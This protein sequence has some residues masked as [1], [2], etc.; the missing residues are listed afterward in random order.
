LAGL[1]CHDREEERVSLRVARY[2]EDILID[3]CDRTWRVVL[4]TPAGWQI[5]NE[6]PLAFTRSGSMQPLPYPVS[7]K[8]SLAPLWELLNVTETQRSLVAGVLLNGYHPEGPYFVTNYVGEHGSAKTS[9]ARSHRQLIDPSQNPLRSPPKEENDPFAQAINNRCVA[10]DNLSYLPLWLSDALC[11]IATG[12]GLSKRKLYT[13]ADEM[14]QELKRPVIINGIED[15]ATRP[16][17]ADRVVQIELETIPDEARITEKVLWHKFEKVRAT[18]FAAILDALVLVLRTQP[19]LKMPPMPRMA[20]AVEWATA[21]ETAFGF[22]RWTFMRP[23][24]RNLDESALTSVEANPVGVAICELLRTQL[25]GEWSGEPTEL[26]ERLEELVTEKVQNQKRWPQNVRALGHA[27]RR[28]APALRRAG[29]SYERA[30]GDRRTIYLSKKCGAGKTTSETSGSSADTGE[31]DTA[32]TS[33]DNAGEMPTSSGIPEGTDV[34]DDVDVIA[35][36][37]HVVTAN[38]EEVM[39]NQ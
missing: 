21:G 3:L 12:G 39:K 36:Y 30:R 24:R 8:G 5:L 38:P 14:A 9:A 25:N 19:A 26:L 28:L 33:S 34:S 13:D 4:V 10:L 11:R 22:K 1:A 16:D 20:D 7:G 27:L 37:S 6:S 17:L 32:G 29:I 31:R 2:G 35:P 15:V 18:I 23:Y